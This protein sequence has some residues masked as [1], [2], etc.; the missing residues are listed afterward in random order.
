LTA[1]RVVVMAASAGGIEALQ[2][3]VGGLP[4]DLGA[5]VLVVLHMAPGATSSL[6]RIL[7][8]AGPLPA[9]AATDGALLEAGRIY[10]CVAD[11]HLL[12]GPGHLHVRRGPRENGHRPAAD[13]LF[14]SAAMYYG[15]NV[16][17]VIL[18]GTL[19]DGTAGLH[20]VRRRGGVAV[21]QDP[22]DALYE[23]MPSNAL[24]YVGADHVVP[25]AEIGPLV[26]RL[27]KEMTV[28]DVESPPSEL[29]QEVTLMESDDRVTESN[30]PGQPSPWP[31]P[32]CNGVLWEIDEGNILRFRC[33]VG[34]AWAAPD[35]LNV[36]EAAVET[37]LWTALRSLE[38]R[39]AL[40]RM[41]ARQARSA[42]RDIGARR[43]ESDVEEYD[44]SVQV[45]RELLTGHP[46]S[47]MDTG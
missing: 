36:Q 45:I 12:V 9:T 15:G 14:R 4:V 23:G 31:C 32:D 24:E 19:S 33:R 6:A 43:F 16:V 11:H 7:D 34:H 17:G 29:Q 47:E 30:H 37:A 25:A 28:V 38:D 42:G 22:A 20:A 35:L 10:V 21:V 39:V 3:V 26:G 2:R 27:V 41:L 46:S 1:R 8:R 40:M 13:P 18:S 5:G 44:R